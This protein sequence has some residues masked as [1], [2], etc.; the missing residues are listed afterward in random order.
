MLVL[1]RAVEDLES[2]TPL[3]YEQAESLFRAAVSTYCDS[4]THLVPS[5]DLAK[6]L[7]GGSNSNLLGKSTASLSASSY[8]M[9]GSNGS[10]ATT[11]GD[12]DNNSEGEKIEVKRNWDWRAGAA[13]LGKNVKGEQVLR[14]LR[15]QVAR[16][17][18]TAWMQI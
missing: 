10:L 11:N 12:D 9:V 17:M 16:D 5:Q 2:V 4:P 3:V 15:A 13:R 7:L 6:S 1:L 8:G 14:V 18:A